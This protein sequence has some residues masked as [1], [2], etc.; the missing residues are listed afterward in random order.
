MRA[1]HK[2]S[3][4]MALFPVPDW[5]FEKPEYFRAFIA[6]YKYNYYL[7]VWDK[8][9]LTEKRAILNWDSELAEKYGLGEFVWPYI[10]L[11]SMDPR[12][13]PFYTDKQEFFLEYGEETPISTEYFVDPFSASGQHLRYS[14]NRIKWKFCLISNGPDHVEDIDEKEIFGIDLS[15]DN[16]IDKDTIYDPTNGINSCGDILLYFD[17]ELL[18]KDLINSIPAFRDLPPLE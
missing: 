1:V 12:F 6:T 3:I 4:N 7:S 8:I 15:E 9:P 5:I 10:E 16:Q 2:Y 14:T 13:N 18:D 17:G 11:R